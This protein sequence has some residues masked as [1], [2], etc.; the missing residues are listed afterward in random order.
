[1]KAL[2]KVKKNKHHPSSTDSPTTTLDLVLHNL[3]RQINDSDIEVSKLVAQGDTPKWLTMAF[4]DRNDWDFLYIA[5]DEF[6][7]QNLLHVFVVVFL[8]FCSGFQLFCSFF[9]MLFVIFDC[10]IIIFGKN[11]RIYLHVEAFF[12][13]VVD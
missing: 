3:Y 2:F 9:Y 1:M 10:F 4:L 7:Y 12:M 13:S 5:R 11:F 6:C 8:L